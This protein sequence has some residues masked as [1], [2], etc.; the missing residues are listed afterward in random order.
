MERKRALDAFR[1][2]RVRVLIATDIAARG[3]D[4]ADIEVVINYD[5]A[6]NRDDHMHRIGRT[7]RYGKKGLAINFVES[8]YHRAR[9][10]GG[11][12]GGNGVH[13]SHSKSTF[14]KPASGS[15]APP[16]APKLGA[17]PPRRS[18]AAPH[19]KASRAYEQKFF[20]KNGYDIPKSA[21]GR[22]S[23]TGS[24]GSVRYFRNGAS[25]PA[26]NQKP[27]F[28]FAPR[29]ASKEKWVPNDKGAI[30]RKKGASLGT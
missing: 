2:G 16:P 19:P 5:R 1:R 30:R 10:E 9:P 13:R 14:S 23:K 8:V 18:P 15:P 20:E 29:P 6:A 7:G 26:T 27:A 12:R 3:I 22:P 11:G 4:V 28:V 25:K 17:Y 24:S 21:K